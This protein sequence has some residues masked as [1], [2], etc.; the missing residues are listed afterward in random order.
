VTFLAKAS[1]IPAGERKLV[2]VNGV[3]V[4]VFH[5]GGRFYALNNACPHRQGPLIRG[6]IVEPVEGSAGA[7]TPCAIRCPMHGWKFDLAT[8]DSHGRPENATVYALIQQDGELY[9]DL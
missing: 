1:E 8:G 5:Q 9:I 3:A 2:K 7:E 6:T 4:A